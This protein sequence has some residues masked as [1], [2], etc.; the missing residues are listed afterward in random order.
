ML[1]VLLTWLCGEREQ[2]EAGTWRC[3]AVPL[4]R[5]FPL[6]LVALFLL[7]ASAVCASGQGLSSF[8]AER[9]RRPSRKGGVA[10]DDIMASADD[11]KFPFAAYD[12]QVELMN[13]I[14]GALNEGQVGIFESPTGTGKSM[15]IICASLRWLKE[16]PVYVPASS[17]GVGVEGDEEL[18]AWVLAHAQKKEEQVRAA[19][20]QAEKERLARARQKMEDDA[21]KREQDRERAVKQHAKL[22]RPTVS[23]VGTSDKGGGGAPQSK[24]D[25]S[26]GRDLDGLVLSD[27]EE[28]RPKE[29]SADEM[30]KL[31]FGESE[32]ADEDDRKEETEVDVRKIIYCSRTHSQ[33]SQFMREV[34]RTHWGRELKAVALASRKSMCINDKVLK[35]KSA[36]RVNAACLDLCRNGGKEEANDGSDVA[37]A[38][39]LQHKQEGSRDKKSFGCPYRDESRMLDLRDAVLAKVQD[40]EDVISWGSNTGTCCAPVPC[41]HVHRL[42]TACFASLHP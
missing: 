2:V 30:L 16:N 33:L 7:R 26:A 28:S 19:A 21:L 12:V 40:I 25:K 8:G 15:S 22:A 17:G 31:L 42:Y 27:S 24:E 37:S 20:I 39:R 5:L 14:Y 10:R 29:K 35:L 11:F 9:G 36:V 38:R 1:R 32:E 18:P 23:M 4:P 34:K 41:A 3:R 13:G 6:L